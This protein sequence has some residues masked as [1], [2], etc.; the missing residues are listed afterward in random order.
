[1]I[2]YFSATGNSKY[3]ADEIAKKTGDKAVSILEAGDTIQIT[4]NE[5]LGI[6]TPTYYLGLP[7]IVDKFL[8]KVKITGTN[9]TYTYVIATYGNLCGS[10]C[11]MIQKHLEKKNLQISAKYSVRMP[12]TWTPIFDVS[13][14]E[15]VAQLNRDEIPQIEEIITHIRNN[16]CG[17]FSKDTAPMLLSKVYH[18][19]YE[20]ARKTSKFQVEEQC[21][22]CGICAKQCPI[23][24]IEIKD[25]RPIWTEEKCETCLGCLHHCPKFA[26]QYGKNTKKHG[27][28]VHP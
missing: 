19:I 4:E 10:T 18:Q 3:V 15:K 28:Y 22:G 26:I 24:A 9:K 1:M 11:T 25:G 20:Y 17:D 23:Q 27:Q 5:K 16:D 6:I 7:V 2:L 12:D 13:D 14:K 21:I 8:D